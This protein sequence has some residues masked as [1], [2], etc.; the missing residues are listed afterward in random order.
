MTRLSAT[1]ITAMVRTKPCSGAKSDAISASTANEPIPGQANTFSTNT[2][3]P[4]RNENTMPSVV[5]T[6]SMALRNA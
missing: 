6:G 5:T 2:L 1:Y 3:A 4:S